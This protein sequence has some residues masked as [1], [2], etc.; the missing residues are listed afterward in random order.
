MTQEKTYNVH[1][2]GNRGKWSFDYHGRPDTEPVDMES[3]VKASNEL[4]EGFNDDLDF[5]NLKGDDYASC[6]IIIND[7]IVKSWFFNV[8]TR[9]WSE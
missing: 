1:I 7:E 3:A 9:T 6:D 4:M 5:Q 8:E 2:S